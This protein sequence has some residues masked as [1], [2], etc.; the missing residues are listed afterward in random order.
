M[1]SSMPPKEDDEEPETTKT[2]A[3]CR[4]KDLEALE[5]DRIGVKRRTGPKPLPTDAAGAV[6][7]GTIQVKPAN[8]SIKTEPPS[9]QGKGLQRRTSSQAESKPKE[10][11]RQPSSQEKKGVTKT[12]SLKREQSDIFKSFSKPQ[13]KVSQKETD[14]SARASPVPQAVRA[15]LADSCM[16]CV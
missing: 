4:E 1:S 10:P 6:N 5:P 13:A 16:P 3:I 7:G 9:V 8:P 14:S 11:A 12:P 15:A 2:V